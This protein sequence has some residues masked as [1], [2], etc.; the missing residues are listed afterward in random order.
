MLKRRPSQFACMSL[1]SAYCFSLLLSITTSAAPSAT[2]PLTAELVTAT[3]RGV[4]DFPWLKAESTNRILSG[5]LA[6][7]RTV[8]FAQQPSATVLVDCTKGH[9]INSA[10]EQHPQALELIV[11]I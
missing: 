8:S 4:F 6:T 7:T 10:L 11:E 9:S 1:V 3:Q 2:Q 5:L